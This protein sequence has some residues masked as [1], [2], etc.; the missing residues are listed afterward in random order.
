MGP[1]ETAR[2]PPGGQRKVIF[3][4]KKKIQS[5]LMLLKLGGREAGVSFELGGEQGRAIQEK[6]R[7]VKKRGAV[8]VGSLPKGI[9][10]YRGTRRGGGGWPE[11]MR[12][13]VQESPKKAEMVGKK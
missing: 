6:K 8:A 4:K 9:Q 3:W 2:G 7:R 10:K 12:K 11:K 1:S 5:S 13:E